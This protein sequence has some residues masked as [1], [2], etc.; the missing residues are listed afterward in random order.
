MNYPK[1]PDEVKVRVRTVAGNRCRY[2]LALQRY[3]LLVLEI[4]HI[5]P[6]AGGG[7][8]DEENLWLACR[9]CNNAKGIQTHGYDP[10][11]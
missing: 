9:L 4:E 11:E 10:L 6:K 3:T 2:C 5:I 7:T 8:D 1:I